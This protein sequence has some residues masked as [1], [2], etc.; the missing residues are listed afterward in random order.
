MP[1]TWAVRLLV[2]VSA[3]IVV[4]VAARTYMRNRRIDYWTL[5]EDANRPSDQD[6]HM[7]IL[8][9][10]NSFI[11]YNGGVEKV[12]A[13]L[14]EEVKGVSMYARRYCPGGYTWQQHLGDAKDPKRSLYRLLGEGGQKRWDYIVFQEQSQAPALGGR[15]TQKSFE[16]LK[17]LMEYAKARSTHQILLMTWGY[18][19]GDGINHPAIFPNYHAMQERLASGYCSLAQ[20]LQDALHMNVSVAPAGLAWEQVHR[21]SAGSA[22][23]ELPAGK[24]L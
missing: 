5:A 16:A 8:F 6:A 1:S 20:R 13:S 18:L 3:A 14:L 17:G 11:H 2:A 19:H 23:A 24:I 12:V 9:V 15:E 7:R 4:L 21:M 22:A 10:G